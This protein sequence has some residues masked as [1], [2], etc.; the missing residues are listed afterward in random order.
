MF[1]VKF[2][3]KADGLE[4]KLDANGVLVESKET[5]K[6]ERLPSQVATAIAKAQP[7]MKNFECKRITTYAEGKATV[8]YEVRG[9]LDGKKG[10]PLQVG[11][12]GTVLER[13]KPK[14]P[15]E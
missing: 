12:D 7:G 5:V 14:K 6:T 9:E 4:L 15:S 1:T 11:A 3:E 8:R 2:G 10:P 13:G